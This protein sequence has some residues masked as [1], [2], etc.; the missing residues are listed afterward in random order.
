MILLF[1]ESCL[2]RLITVPIIPV[3]KTILIIWFALCGALWLLLVLSACCGSLWVVARG[4]RFVII[5]GPN[6]GF[7]PNFAR[8]Y[9]RFSLFVS[10]VPTGCWAG[11]MTFL[12]V[13]LRAVAALHQPMI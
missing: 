10:G 11:Y 12:S 13:V 3:R 8:R 5:S 7:L 2:S 4:P 9:G 6:I 1:I